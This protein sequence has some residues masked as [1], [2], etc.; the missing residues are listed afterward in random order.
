[1][2]L[3][4]YLTNQYL[5]PFPTRRS[6]DLETFETVTGQSNAEILA[7]DQC[8]GAKHFRL[9]GQFLLPLRLWAGP[10]DCHHL[11]LAGHLRKPRRARSEE[12]TSELQSRVDLVCRLLLE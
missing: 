7:C 6:S 11:L 9:P 5:H 4:R 1:I 10:A 12:H 2:L 8:R 3:P